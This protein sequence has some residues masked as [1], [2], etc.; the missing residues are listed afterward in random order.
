M[1]CAG[2]GAMIPVG[3]KFCSGCGSSQTNMLACAT[4]GAAV[5]GQS[6]TFC[7]ACGSSV[8]RNPPP[9]GQSRAPLATPHFSSQARA[10]TNPQP[11]SPPPFATPTL[12]SATGRATGPGP[13][14]QGHGKP[15]RRGSKGLVGI[16][17]VLLIGLAYL[18]WSRLLP[19]NSG[20]GQSPTQTTTVPNQ[21]TVDSSTVPRQT[22]RDN[23]AAPPSADLLSRNGPRTLSLS[24]FNPTD[25]NS[26]RTGVSEID[27]KFFP[28]A[29]IFS[30][31][32]QNNRPTATF[33]LGRKYG[34]L[35]TTLGIGDTSNKDLRLRLQISIDGVSMF[36]QEI[37]KGELWPVDIAVA[38][39]YS[40]T[41]T[42]I[43][44][45]QGSGTG[46]FAAAEVLENT[47]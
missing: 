8:V 20:I 38:N 24:T 40:V 18:S 10:G 6:T 26:Y 4:C 16:T 41:F 31:Y 43:Q 22:T 2:C 37:G 25:T 3:D 44:P 15:P 9:T 23:R 29:I 39:I 12:R 19:G 34:R 13:S 1:T 11:T 27:G 17:L 35:K 47:N 46:V 28:D 32:S 21:T 7:S 42:V 36:D 33:V 5:V 14:Q 45:G 30:A